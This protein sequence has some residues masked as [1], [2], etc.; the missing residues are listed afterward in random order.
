MLKKL[1]TTLCAG[2]VLNVA[3]ASAQ[4]LEIG[5][6]QSPAGLDPHVVTAF[7]SVMVVNGTIYEGLTAI[8][9]NLAVVPALAESWTVSPDGKTYTFKLRPNVKFHDGSAMD[10]GDVVSTIRRVQGKEIASP[11]ASRVA[12]IETAAAIDPQ[13]VELKLK[14][15][16]APLLSSLATIAIVPSE[17]ETN[18]DALQKTPVGT[19]PFRFQEWQ[20]NGY[21]LL[22]KNDAYWQAGTPKLSGLKF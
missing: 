9:K 8:D 10:A 2:F 16:S 12:S 19:G 13:T 21:I 14:E 17:V 5:I 6:D 22:S 4:T 1:C 15:P 3:A 18:K 11:L 7:S 20:P